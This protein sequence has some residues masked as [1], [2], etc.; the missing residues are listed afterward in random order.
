MHDVKGKRV[1]VFGLGHFGGGINVS[2]WLCAQGA[3]VLVTDK[4]SREY[5]K[6]SVAQ[7]A[8]LPIEFRLGEHRVENF[9]SADLVVI[10]PAIPPTNELLIATQKAGVPVTLEIALFIERCRAKIIGVTATKGKSTTTSM[11][12]DMLRQKHAVHVGGNLGGSLLFDLPKIAPTDLVVLELS[13]YMLEHLRPRAWSPHVAVVGMIGRDHLTWHGGEEAYVDA[14][15]NLVRFQSAS[16]FAILN[17]ESPA[18]LGFADQARSKV[19]RFDSKSSKPF[20]L[21]VAGEHNQLNAQG[22]FA[23]ATLFGVTWDDAQRAMHAYTP[24]PHRLQLVHESNGVKWIND[25]IATIPEAAIVAMRAYPKGTVI[26]IIGGDDKKLDMRA[27][28]Q[29]LARECKAVLTIGLLGP[30]LAA[31]IRVVSDRQAQLIECETLERAANEARKIAKPGDVILL[32]TGCA[33]YDQF[34]NFEERG[35]EFSSLATKLG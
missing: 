3:K 34:H 30:Q 15:K 32:S 22:A 14:K 17:E 1:T 10:S 27:M 9:T 8:G 18:S 20:D 31:M 12:G 13:S 29:A 26:Q 28:C 11:L 6:D 4:Q 35:E 5:L 7:L 24:L 21:P 2:K 19:I 25:S 16:D 33:S 23:A